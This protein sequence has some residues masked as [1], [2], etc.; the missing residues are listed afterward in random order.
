MIRDMWA[1]TEKLPWTAP[2]GY[3]ISL[4]FDSEWVISGFGGLGGVPM[5]FPTQNANKAYLLRFESI[6]ECVVEKE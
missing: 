4:Y 1:I 5:C 6:I 2:T 3:K